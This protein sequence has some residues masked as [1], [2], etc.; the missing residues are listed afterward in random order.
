V[1]SNEREGILNYINMR[2]LSSVVSTV[3]EI[4]RVQACLSH[5]LSA[6]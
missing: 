4:S 2:Q 3:R 5:L 1:I 6:S